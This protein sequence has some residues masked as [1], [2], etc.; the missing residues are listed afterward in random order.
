MRAKEQNKTKKGKEKKEEKR[1]KK[2]VEKII[3]WGKVRFNSDKSAC[4][5]DT[6]STAAGARR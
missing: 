6:L 5:R 2:K 4:P 1:K 3:M